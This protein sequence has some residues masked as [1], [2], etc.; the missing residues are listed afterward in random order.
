MSSLSEL[1]DQCSSSRFLLHAKKS[2]R[3]DYHFFCHLLYDFLDTKN[4]SEVW[5]ISKRSSSSSS[6]AINSL[7]IGS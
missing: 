3:H 2:R 4:S 5:R 6:S 1:I 7:S